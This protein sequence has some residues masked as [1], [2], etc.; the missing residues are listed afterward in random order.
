MG[1]IEW[2]DV[3]DCDSTPSSRKG[4]AHQAV[5]SFIGTL[6]SSQYVTPVVWESGQACDVEGPAMYNKSR[7][8]Q[9]HHFNPQT[10]PHPSYLMH[11]PPPV[12]QI[13]P[14]GVA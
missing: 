9:H 6:P 12:L 2:N 7:D 8:L 14:F 11:L 10:L 5:M 4:G 3:C 13:H 1:R